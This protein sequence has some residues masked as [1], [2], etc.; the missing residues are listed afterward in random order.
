MSPKRDAAGNPRG[1]RA[2]G[3]LSQEEIINAA[4]GL[5]ERDGVDGLSM[6]VLA[7]C[8]NAGVMSIY[9]YFRNKDELLLA[10][11]D[12]A[13]ADVVS[14][15]PPIADGRWDDELVG[16]TAGMH[17]ALRENSLYLELCRAQPRALVLRPAVIPALAP[18]FEDQLRLFPETTLSASE[19]VRVIILLATFARGFALLQ[20][21][22]EEEQNHPEQALEAAVQQ[23]N[24]AKFPMLRAASNA[25]AAA[26]LSDASFHT[27][28][29]LMVAGLR[30]ELEQSPCA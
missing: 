21:G 20:V 27:G 29:R 2:R 4:I 13:L 10:M 25:G 26:S 9:W 12:R 5:V 16:V 8:L 28:I 14:A 18:R 3:S 30:A 17:R 22:A 15:L 23:L 19:A 24:P 7:K 1:R 6:P 11:A